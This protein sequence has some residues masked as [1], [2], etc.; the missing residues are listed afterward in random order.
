MKTKELI[1]N[2]LGM[3]I[4]QFAETNGFDLDTINNLLLGR[5][6]GNRKGTKAYNLKQFL[7][8]SGLYKEEIK[9]DELEIDT[10]NIKNLLLRN[11][12]VLI[13]NKKINNNETFKEIVKYTHKKIPAILDLYFDTKVRDYIKDSYFSEKEITYKD[14]SQFCFGTSDGSKEGSK[15]Y[16]VKQKLL[17]DGILPLITIKK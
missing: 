8:S 11:F 12:F 17:E 1:K 4:K 5:T 16:Y 2:D 15:A 13:F 14:F 7:I 3:N 10:D 6:L 9:K